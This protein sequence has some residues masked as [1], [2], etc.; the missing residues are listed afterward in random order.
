MKLYEMAIEDYYVTLYLTK[1]K[2][3]NTSEIVNVSNSQSLN[4]LRQNVSKANTQA[5]IHS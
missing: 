1:S 2:I 3:E 5:F 4:P